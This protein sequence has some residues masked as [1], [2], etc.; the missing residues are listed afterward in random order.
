MCFSI[1]VELLGFWNWADEG[2]SISQVTE[3]ARVKQLQQAHRA[4]CKDHHPNADPHREQSSAKAQPETVEHTSPTGDSNHPY[5]QVTPEDFHHSSTK[6]VMLSHIA[7]HTFLQEIK[8]QWRQKEM[9][10]TITFFYAIHIIFLPNS[11]HNCVHMMLEGFHEH[12]CPL[13]HTRAHS[14]FLVIGDWCHISWSNR[15][16]SYHAKQ[17]QT[18]VR[19]FNSRLCFF[20]VQ[21]GWSPLGGPD[22]GSF[23][24]MLGPTNPCLLPCCFHMHQ[25][26][27]PFLPLY[28]PFPTLPPEHGGQVGGLIHVP[29]IP[30]YT[31]M[32]MPPSTITPMMVTMPM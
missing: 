13:K 27:N 23:V 21:S 15:L 32:S 20:I 4:S 12:G 31:A 10:V 5:L 1:V 30:V 29:L 3:S 2:Y 28:C 8:T 16:L 22:F 14:P 25:H 11:S 9:V 19:I 6:H 26:T 24:G 7:L 17:E 18:S